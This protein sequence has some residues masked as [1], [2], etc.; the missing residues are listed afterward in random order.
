MQTLSIGELAKRSGV[1]ERALRFYET[2]GLMKPVRTEARQR[3]YRYSDILRLQQIQLLKKAGFTLRDIQAMTKGSTLNATQILQVQ[4]AMLR[5]EAERIRTAHEAVSA[6]LERLQDD[7]NVSLSTLCHII[8]MG[9]HAVS[10]EKW[11]KVWNKFYTEEEQK[12]WRAAKDAVPDEIVKAHEAA[13]PALIART[14]A[15]VARGADPASEEAL[16]VVQEWNKMTQAIY[17]I[18]PKLAGS[19][20]KLY[21]NLDDWPVDGPEAPFSPEVW[22][23]IK[24]AEV[25]LKKSEA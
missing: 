20:A 13:W 25:A 1:S 21:D 15:L 4:E 11:K 12:R 18:D 10:E 2:K 3:A 5:T 16:T 7:S 9:E 23:F 17:D 6:A 24:K 8:K 19:A 22:R 14:E